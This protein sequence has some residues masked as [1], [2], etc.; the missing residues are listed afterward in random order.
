MHCFLASIAITIAAF[1]VQQTLLA[2]SVDKQTRNY[3]REF[4]NHHSSPATL[5]SKGVSRRKMK[6]WATSKNLPLNAIATLPHPQSGVS[7]RQETFLAPSF[8]KQT[9]NYDRECSNHHP[10]LTTLSSKR[11]SH[12]KIKWRVIYTNLPVNAR[13]RLP[14]PRSRH[15]QSQETSLVPPVDKQTHNYD[16]ECSNHHPSL[17]TLRSKGLSRSK[18][19]WWATYTN[20]PVNA[21]VRLLHHWSGD[22]QGQER[23]LAPS[24][25]K[26]THNYDRECSN[27]HPSLPTLTS[28]GFSR[29]KMKLWAIYTNLLVN[30]IVRLPHPRSRDRQDEETFL[31]FS[32]TSKRA[33]MTQSAQTTIHPWQP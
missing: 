26:Q 12:S 23:L 17:T 24:V 29:S 31:A 4:S 13:V 10:S 18:M 20:L 8:D 11:L 1:Q 27:H 32:L 3:D 21:I 22:S 6:W 7:E 14:H 2:P 25:D 28:K 16:T 33:I 9:R 30:A 5:R 19:K 15:S